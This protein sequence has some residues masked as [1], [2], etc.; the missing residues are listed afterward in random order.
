M[1]KQKYAKLLGQLQNALSNGNA[2]PDLVDKI[3]HK[4]TKAEMQLKKGKK[5]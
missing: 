4:I 5:K 2:A 3:K 1:S